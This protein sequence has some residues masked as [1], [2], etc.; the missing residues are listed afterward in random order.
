MDPL[1]IT[2]GVASLLGCCLSTGVALRQFRIGA[3]EVNSVIT[4]M[5]AD[6]RAF[7][8]V[9]ESLETTFEDMN[10]DRPETGHIGAHWNN[11]SQLLDDCQQSLVKLQLVIEDV[12]KQVKILD[13]ARKQIRIKVAADQIITCRQEVQT[14]KDALQLSLQT[15]TL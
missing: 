8:T 10:S 4:A 11:I 7:R 3:S 2:V 13:R 15:I 1:S 12:S 14:Y 6:L 9:L 5:M